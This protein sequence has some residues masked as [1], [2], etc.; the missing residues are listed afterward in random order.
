MGL[1][2][3]AAAGAFLGYSVDA[4]NY[5]VGM[6]FVDE[7]SRN[8]TPGK[9]ALVAEV[10]EYW[11]VP[12]DLRMETLEGIVVRQWR[13]DVEHDLIENQI[14]A[15][16]AE[17]SQL[18][19]EYAQAKDEHK[20][21][22]EIRIGVAEAKLKAAL[23]REKVKVETLKQQADAKIKALQKQAATASQETKTKIE[24]RV[25]EIQ[26]ECEKLAKQRAT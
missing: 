22:L 25:S 23:E 6:E 14:Q 26:A 10:D 19:A 15:R 11:T 8:L 21:R 3:G 17:L 16:K 4:S 13:L 1:A 7:V 2:A 9:S 12:L 5:G 24:Q 18:K 20:V